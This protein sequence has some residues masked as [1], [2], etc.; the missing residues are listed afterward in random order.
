MI[1][2]KKWYLVEW[3]GYDQS[4]DTWEPEEN[5]VNAEQKVAE[6]WE[7]KR[8]AKHQLIAAVMA[9]LFTGKLKRRLKKWRTDDEGQRQQS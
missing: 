1:P 6:F 2:A 3:E 9:A 5:F 8:K 7:R 4:H